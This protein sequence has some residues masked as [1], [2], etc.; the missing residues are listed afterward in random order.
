MA[1]NT[2]KNGKGDKPRPISNYEKY[3]NNWDDIFDK[4]KKKVEKQK[5]TCENK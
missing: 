2:V 1:D 3:I 4:S 5:E